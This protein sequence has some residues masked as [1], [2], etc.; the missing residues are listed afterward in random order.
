MPLM[1]TRWPAA[2]TQ[3]RVRANPAMHDATQGIFTLDALPAAH[4][5]IPGLGEWL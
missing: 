3:T 5:P 1:T 2:A 4:L